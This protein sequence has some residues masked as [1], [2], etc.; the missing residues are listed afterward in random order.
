MKKHSDEQRKAFV[1]AYLARNETLE[2]IARR[3]GTSAPYIST[4]AAR[5]GVQQRHTGSKRAKII[6]AFKAN[7]D[8]SFQ[9]IA[10]DF[11]TTDRYVFSVLKECGFPVET[12]LELGRAA[13]A[14]G[15]TTVEK[16]K[17]LASK[18]EAA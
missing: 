9:S 4:L 17:A 18:I 10:R 6:A 13:R 8:R 3:F 12:D 5:A 14:F 16:I 11:K 15:L 2:S 1:D 7:P